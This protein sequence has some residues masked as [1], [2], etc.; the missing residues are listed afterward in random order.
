[1]YARA[2]QEVKGNE[3]FSEQEVLKVCAVNLQRQSAA[4]C[5]FRN[6][7]LD[8]DHTEEPSNTNRRVEIKIDLAA[9]AVSHVGLEKVCRK[10]EASRD[11]QSIPACRPDRRIS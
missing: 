5:D 4:A 2:V 1:M 11:L 6:R 3:V 10:R 9:Q 7:T 8:A